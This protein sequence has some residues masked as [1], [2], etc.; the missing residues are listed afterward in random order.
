MAVGDQKLESLPWMLA[1]LGAPTS[2]LGPVAFWECHAVP[3]LEDL[4]QSE[5]ES[6]CN[7]P[8]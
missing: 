8:Q 5:R 1:V 2:A 3:T 7:I 6:G 4:P